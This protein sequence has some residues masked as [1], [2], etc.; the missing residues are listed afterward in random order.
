MA[1]SLILL[2]L[3][4]SAVSA[5]GTAG[6]GGVT[7]DCIYNA[8]NLDDLGWNLREDREL[9]TK[10]SRDVQN[11]LDTQ[12]PRE[13]FAVFHERMP[14]TSREGMIYHTSVIDAWFPGYVKAIQMHDFCN[15]HPFIGGILKFFGLKTP[16]L[17][18]TDFE[19][20][21]R[22]IKPRLRALVVNE[23]YSMDDGSTQMHDQVGIYLHGLFSE[24]NIFLFSSLLRAIPLPLSDAQVSGL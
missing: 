18:I 7:S 16:M 17:D 1:A 23:H 10:Y 4:V 8:F 14:A 19:T 15:R 21:G 5:Q 2:A 3:A 12:H 11:T 24:F 22:A 13:Y 9:L 6:G 20:F